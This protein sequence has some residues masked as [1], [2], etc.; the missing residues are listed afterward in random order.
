MS[1]RNTFITNPK[2]TKVICAAEWV[3]FPPVSFI[4]LPTKELL[5]LPWQKIAFWPSELWRL[6]S[7]HL[8][9]SSAGTHSINRAR[10]AGGSC[11][12]QERWLI[13]TYLWGSMH[14]KRTER[15]A[16]LFPVH[17]GL[18]IRI[19]STREP[20]AVDRSTN[21]GKVGTV[22]KWDFCALCTCWEN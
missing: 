17:W 9:T 20:P 10:S 16:I 11:R 7:A 15:V 6:H 4:M 19:Q 5:L 13:E 3:F 8:I 14:T 18:E 21:N 1:H 22:G 2:Y 12:S